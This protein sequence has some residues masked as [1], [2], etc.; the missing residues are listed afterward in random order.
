MNGVNGA[1]GPPL[2]SG[3]LTLAARTQVSVR[4][5]FTPGTSVTRRK[6]DASGVS[7]SPRQNHNRKR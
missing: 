4:F 3:M 7:P 5:H 2:V 1:V 6:L